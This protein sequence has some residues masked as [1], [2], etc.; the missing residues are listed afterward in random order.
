MHENLHSGHKWSF[1]I[2]I[3]DLF[4]YERTLKIA[5]SANHSN[6]AN[7]KLKKIHSPQLAELS[8]KYILEWTHLFNFY[9]NNATIKKLFLTP[10]PLF[11]DLE[12]MELDSFLQDRHQIA[13]EQ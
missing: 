13:Q 3:Y 4:I 2:P 9:N 11:F 7:L 10:K 6:F 1:R 5:D 8:L 12:I